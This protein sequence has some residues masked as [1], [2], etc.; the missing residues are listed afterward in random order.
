MDI[1]DVPI[2]VE[3][4]RGCGYRKPGG[5]YL[6]SD[7]E[8]RDCGRLPIP[9]TACP[10]C[11][12]GIKQGRGY[13]WIDL[14]ALAEGH[15]C[16]RKECGGC[17]MDHLEDL[18]AVLLIWIG[19]EFYPTTA[20]YCAE[21]RRMG[22]SRRVS[23]VPAGFRIGSSWVALAHPAAISRPCAAPGCRRGLVP[24]PANPI[25]GRGVCAACEGTGVEEVPGLFGL[26]RPDRIEYVCRGDEKPEELEALAARGLTLV[27][28]RRAD[29]RLSLADRMDMDEGDDY[30]GPIGLHIVEPHK[31]D[32]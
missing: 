2:V 14:A 7:G 13:R 26:Y 11:G 19:A 10:T 15:P 25:T 9:L 16:S 17:A 27:R 1:H 30:H 12:A 18:G 4:P 23:A 28:V 31:E 24:D 21:G 29:G 8:L 32:Q 20:D 5:L 6:R 3:G 22:L